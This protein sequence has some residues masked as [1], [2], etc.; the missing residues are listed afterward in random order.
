[1]DVN[2]AQA[3]QLL[4][5]TSHAITKYIR[6]GKLNAKRKGLKSFII[7]LNELRGFCEA[8]KMFFDDQLAQQLEQAA[9]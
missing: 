5:V 1:M 3:A 4:G 8:N 2:T 6:T 7:N 9:Q